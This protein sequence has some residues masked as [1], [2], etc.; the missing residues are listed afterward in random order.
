[1][2]K[3]ITTLQKICKFSFLATVFLLPLKFG[4]ML[5]PGVPH[6]YPADVYGAVLNPLPPS[7]FTVWSSVLLIITLA[8][9]GFP[10]KL[11]WKSSSGRLLILFLLLPVI[12]L[13]GFIN[14]DNLENA[15][16]EFEYMLGFAAFAA[17][18]AIM[19]QSEPEKIRSQILNTAAAGTL[20]TALGGAYQYF[21]GFDEL[22][23]FIAEQEKLHKIALAPELKARAFDVR[24]YA[25]FS[26]ASA[27]A[28]FL[29]LTGVLTAVRAFRWGS[30][31]EPVKLSQKLFT[32]LAVLLTAGIFLTTKGRSAFL[33][34][35]AA[36]AFTG[37]LQL[38]SRK[39]KIFLAIAAV[40]AVTAGAFYIHYAGRGFSSMTERVGYLQS[41]L[42]MVLEH[43]L[44]GG[45]W[46]SFTYYHAQHKNFGNEELAKDPHN[47]VAAFAAQT[48]I[49]GGLA[50]SILW[51]YILYLAGKRMKKERSWENIALFFGLSAFSLHILM[52]LDWQVPALMAYYSLFALMT[53]EN[54]P[55]QKSASNRNIS[56]GVL[57]VLS[58]FAVVGGIHWA[59]AENAFGNM[60][61][62]SGQEAG[63]YA[64][65]GSS[66]E[67]DA[68]AEKALKLAP[69]S[70]SIYNAWAMDKLRRGDLD[71]AG[72]LFR[73]TIELAPRSY[74]AH[75]SL[76]K[77]YAALGKKDLAEK[78]TAEADRLFPYYKVFFNKHNSIKE[79]NNNE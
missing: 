23:K 76:G 29:A 73:K 36:A 48:G 39:V 8:A 75:K 37:F 15:V 26:F 2:E 42:N 53:A 49:F 63:V 43:P 25:T 46:G 59:A 72:E 1:M 16:S 77:L 56:V 40:T 60:L 55:E 67:V 79:N 28:G 64:K 12:T 33:S 7:A 20:C 18:S 22:K 51:L 19:L 54:V 52:D 6:T 27:L 78:H 62:I 34:V 71:R 10:E 68:A 24:T 74:A 21:Y 9:H 61:E 58:L 57:A 65:A 70:S 32:A 47:I 13:L 50:I 3:S 44:C 31:F 38:K 69:Y 4:A 41:S 30:L 5:L 66:Y 35:I 11:P 14:P 45:G 17:V